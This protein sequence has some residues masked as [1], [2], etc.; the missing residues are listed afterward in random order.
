MCQRAGDSTHF[1]PNPSTAGLPKTDIRLVSDHVLSTSATLA[2]GKCAGVAAST[3][4]DFLEAVLLIPPRI[5]VDLHVSTK[6]LTA[7]A[8]SAPALMRVETR[9]EDVGE[10]RLF[11]GRER[12]RGR[13][14]GGDRTDMGLSGPFH[15][16]APLESGGRGRL[17]RRCCSN[18]IMRPLSARRE[19]VLIDSGCSSRRRVFASVRFEPSVRL[20]TSVRAL[21]E[22]TG[23]L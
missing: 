14:G 22:R 23:H 21:K 12:D 13:D 2:S 19:A 1:V 15:R 20:R 17:G 10:D 5:G 9:S 4:E 16:H 11:V 3:V 18:R 7:H 8:A 6:H